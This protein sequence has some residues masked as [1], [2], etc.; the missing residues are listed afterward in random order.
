MSENEELEFLRKNWERLEPD[1]TDRGAVDPDASTLEV[2][3]WMQAAWSQVEVE[4]IAIPTAAPEVR[5]R[6]AGQL[7]ATAAFIAIALYGWT[8]AEV[9]P[10]SPKV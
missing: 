3:A 1:V 2:L 5:W 4:A 8:G 9:A 6:R 7:A 10:R